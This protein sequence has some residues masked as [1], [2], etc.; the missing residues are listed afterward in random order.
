MSRPMTSRYVALWTCF[1]ASAMFLVFQGGKVALMIFIMVSIL[2][3]YLFLGRWSGI[4]KA[5]GRREIVHPHAGT[6]LEA[7]ASLGVRLRFKIPGYWPIPYVVVKD[8]LVRKNGE[9]QLFE[10]SF[11]PDWKRRGEIYYRT[12]PLRRGIYIFTETACITEDIFGLFRHTGELTLE[13]T[14]RVLPRTVTIREWRH[15]SRIAKGIYDQSAFARA[16]RETTQI[17]GVRE[18]VYGDRI[19]RIHWN[20]SA[21]T[22]VWKSKEFERESLPKMVLV[23]DAHK[24]SYRISERF[25]L[26][27]SIA[28]SLL[29]YGRHLHL[30]QGLIATGD[31]P[32]V[33]RPSRESAH[34]E[35]MANYLIGVEADGSERLPLALKQLG[36]RV[37]AKC[38]IVLITPLPP[39]EL[40]SLRWLAAH[41]Q[42]VLCHLWIDDALDLNPTEKND[43]PDIKTYRIR[44]LEQLPQLL[45]GS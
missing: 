16:L 5:E 17:D 14:V 28:A 45:E 1:A 6:E 44:S 19:S 40:E 3:A 2:S 18:Y 33:F 27:V 41:Q 15:F 29:K 30:S 24:A 42:S 38:F 20:A 23:L 43:R 7:G 39:A 11:I 35:S 4:V 26:A 25:E 36:S 31:K 21:R 37:E 22:G 9:T 32:I 10:T 8:R 12:P 34:R 13:K